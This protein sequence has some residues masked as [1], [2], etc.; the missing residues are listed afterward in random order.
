M[1]GVSGDRELAALGHRLR[2]T[3]DKG[4]MR[5]LRKGLE[6]GLKPLSST[7]HD[8]SPGYVP[9]GYEAT[10]ASALFFKTS[11]KTTGRQAAVEHITYAKGSRRPRQIKLIDK[12]GLRHPVFGRYRYNRFGSRRQNPWVRQVIRAGFWSDQVADNRDNLRTEM[13]D[14]TRR[15]AD[16]IVRG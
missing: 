9:A 16:K 6:T 7:I 4:L 2:E 10:F 13:R 11:V 1:S 5:E 12:G 8:K 14:V 15:I 3:A